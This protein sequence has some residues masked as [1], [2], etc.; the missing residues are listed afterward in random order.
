MKR[1]ISLL[2][3]ILILLSCLAPLVCAVSDSRTNVF[4]DAVSY[5]CTLD[6][7]T[8]KI[9]VSGTVNHDVMTKYPGY[10]IQLYSVAPGEYVEDVINDVDISPLAQTDMTIKFTFSITAMSSIE[11][12]SKYAIIFCSES[13]AK[14]VAGTPKYPAVSSNFEYLR[15]DRSVYKAVL[16]ESSALS[17]EV[18]AGMVIVDVDM[19]K[20]L[21]G[22]SDSIL[23]PANDNYISFSRSYV[24]ELDK[25]MISARVSN[26]KIYLRFLFDPSDEM[27]CVA[28][29]ENTDMRGFPNIYDE[30]TL[31]YISSLSKFLMDRYSDDKGKISGVIMGDRAD[32]IVSTNYVGAMSMDQYADA[33]VLYLTVV[34]AAMRMTD[35]S[36]D[37]VIPI[38]DK[39]GYSS[40]K[41][42][43][44]QAAEFL[45]YVISEL[46]YGTSGRF[47]CSVMIQSD[48]VP[49]G[50]SNNN[51]SSGVNT[52]AQ[53]GGGRIH[54]DTI[55]HFTDHIRKLSNTYVS[56]PTNVIFM[57]E[58]P[59]D[60]GG[61]ALNT[62]YAY[63][64]YK[65]YSELDVSSLVVSASTTDQLLQ[66]A[67][68][69][70]YIDTQRGNNVTAPLLK[71]FGA[72]NWEEVIG[73]SAISVNSRAYFEYSALSN[74][75]EKTYKSSFCYY[76]FSD[77][78]VFNNTHLGENTKSVYSTPDSSGNR[79]LQARIEPLLPGESAECIYTLDYA[80]SF[81]Y[82]PV[83]AV[84]IGLD[85]G[86]ENSNALYELRLTIGAATSRAVCKAVITSGNTQTLFFDISNYAESRTADY[87]RIGVRAL[88]GETEECM[89]RIYDL[90]GYSNSYSNDELSTLIEEHRAT[91]RSTENT[92]GATTYRTIISVI[93]V[94]FVLVA[95]GAGLFMVF[96]KEDS[97]KNT[98]RN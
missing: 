1:K 65:L 29:V 50:I 34:A 10:K 9:V 37:I 88:T 91:L 54:A 83:I 27:F 43:N 15:G 71:Y 98:E 17:A 69:I 4:S 13:G 82:T 52:E 96:K 73:V 32:D 21:G 20:M 78:D 77:Y 19:G 41:N 95:V 31:D 26:A 57:W 48:V 97:K 86:V 85:D 36:L 70:T 89:L 64:Y 72:K 35:P 87:V 63:I 58:P 61:S 14:Y 44:T 7:V 6:E 60:L 80:E 25:K 67:D 23:Y 49:F 47:K 24:E 79:S 3:F 94:F 74:V 68:T 46:E 45:D 33:Y 5:T 8:G 12:Y 92:A 39:D 76:T 81:K 56:A 28:S 55:K 62:A 42:T 30:D 11:R 40:N 84:T 59:A 75:S 66:L 2:M 51:I 38:S 16:C 53:F 93:C 22:G 90:K 18:G